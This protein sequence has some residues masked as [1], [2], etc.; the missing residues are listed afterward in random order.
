MIKSVEFEN[1]RNLKGKYEFNNVINVIFGK[2][3]SGKTNVLDGIKL[4]FSTISNDY[5]RINKSD[6]KDSDD[7]NV[8]MIKIELE[9]NSIPTLNFID[10]NGIKKFR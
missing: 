5:F 8:I 2:N 9:V 10:E 4:A 6:F 3:N 7:S 1:F